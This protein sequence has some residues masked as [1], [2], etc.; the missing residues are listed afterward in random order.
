MLAGGV[1][2]DLVRH[3]VTEPLLCGRSACRISRL[4]TH[5]GMSPVVKDLDTGKVMPVSWFSCDWVALIAGYRGL[6]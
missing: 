6:Q 3:M 1:P 5:T 2:A 4:T